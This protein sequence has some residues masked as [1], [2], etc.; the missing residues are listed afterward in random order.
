MATKNG[1]TA[2]LPAKPPITLLK[3]PQTS[4]IFLSFFSNQV[5][6][7]INKKSGFYDF[8]WLDWLKNNKQGEKHGNY[9]SSDLR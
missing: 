9:R 3:S 7:F 4:A 2:H 6:Q 5:T 1:A 8:F